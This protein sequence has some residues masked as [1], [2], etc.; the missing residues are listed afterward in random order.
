MIVS[1]HINLDSLQR[2]VFIITTTSYP[3]TASFQ[4]LQWWCVAAVWKTKEN[5]Q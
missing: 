1:L 3:C 2:N 5:D 4:G